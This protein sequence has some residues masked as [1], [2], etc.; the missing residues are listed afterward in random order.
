MAQR[1]KKERPGRFGTEVTFLPR[2]LG[3]FTANTT[4]TFDIPTPVRSAIIER[5]TV[6]QRVLVADA[7]GTVLMT[8]KKWD[9]SAGAAVTLTAATSLEGDNQTAK[10]A[11]VVPLLTTLTDDQ[12]RID[13]GDY[14]YVEVVNN[15]AAIDTQATDPS[16]VVEVL[17]LE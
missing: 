17:V 3:A 6:Q 8:V 5:I 4:T 2:L 16:V 14:L 11:K 1:H 13:S 7:D 15:S 12:L 10:V 9:S